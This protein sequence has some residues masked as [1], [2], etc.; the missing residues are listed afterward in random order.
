[1]VISIEVEE[2]WKNSAPVHDKKFE[3]TRN[4]KELLQPKDE[5]LHEI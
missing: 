5:H 3:Q 4:R 1:M 2:H